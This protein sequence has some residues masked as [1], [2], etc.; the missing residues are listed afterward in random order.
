MRNYLLSGCVMVGSGHCPLCHTRDRDNNA[1]CALRALLIVHC[2]ICALCIAHCPLLIVSCSGEILV[3]LM[4]MYMHEC[5]SWWQLRLVYSNCYTT[6]K[7]ALAMNE[8]NRSWT[9]GTMNDRFPKCHELKS[10]NLT[11]FKCVIKG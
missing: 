6:P 5:S 3:P 7:L 4:T 1:N 11:L 9:L 10:T 2:A 8:F